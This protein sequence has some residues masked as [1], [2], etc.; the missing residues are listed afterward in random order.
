MRKTQ[1][2]VGQVLTIHT[3]VRVSY[4]AQSM[5][6]VKRNLLTMSLEI[7]VHAHMY[8]YSYASFILWIIRRLAP[9]SQPFSCG[10]DVRR[11]RLWVKYRGK[12]FLCTHIQ[13]CRWVD[14]GGNMKKNKRKKKVPRLGFSDSLGD[15]EVV[16]VLGNAVLHITE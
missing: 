3:E 9:T 2:D 1:S 5:A 6:A 7:Y 12:R 10:F 16:R 13:L 14:G 11:D 4:A 8:N 15:S